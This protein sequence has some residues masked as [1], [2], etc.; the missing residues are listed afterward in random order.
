[1][2]P[3]SRKRC[4]AT[5]RTSSPWRMPCRSGRRID[6]V[7]G[8]RPS[9]NLPDFSGS[10][11]VAPLQYWRGMRLNAAKWM[12]INS[13]RSITQIAYECGF[14]DSSHLIHW[15]KREFNVTPSKL[16]RSPPRRAPS[17]NVT[18]QTAAQDEARN[19]P[20]RQAAT[21]ATPSRSCSI[22][23]ACRSPPLAPESIRRCASSCTIRK[24]RP[25]H[26]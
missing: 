1:M 18:A 2:L 22:S 9:A 21:R 14:T 8:R 12:V 4:R 13:D 15:F 10:I 3:T 11:C 23:P 16:S 19:S 5:F 26:D 6:Y 25:R 24:L 17:Y 7:P 20:R